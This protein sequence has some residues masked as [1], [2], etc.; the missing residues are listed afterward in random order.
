MRA[1]VLMATQTSG[2]ALEL[3][4]AGGRHGQPNSKNTKNGV[5]APRP[6]LTPLCSPAAAALP[7][8]ALLSPRAAVTRLRVPSPVPVDAPVPAPSSIPFRSR[9]SVPCSFL[10]RSSRVSRSFPVS[11]CSFL[12]SSHGSPCDV[13]RLSC[14][15]CCA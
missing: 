10:V 15:S 5:P 14:R 1:S 6:L 9:C 12:V 7:P 4:A 11:Y 8:S 2:K 13:L 3:L